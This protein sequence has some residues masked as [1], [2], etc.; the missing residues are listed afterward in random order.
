M[1]KKPAEFHVFRIGRV[2]WR[3]IKFIMG[4]LMWFAVFCC[5]L[6][7]AV[8]IYDATRTLIDTGENYFQYPYAAEGIYVDPHGYAILLRKNKRY[9]MC[10]VKDC[11]EGDWYDMLGPRP[12]LEWV[13]RRTPKRMVTLE[14]IYTTALGQRFYRNVRMRHDKDWHLPWYQPQPLVPA[15]P[16]LVGQIENCRWLGDMPCFAYGHA[17]DSFRKSASFADPGK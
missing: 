13:L 1:D 8:L 6:M 9:R 16:H 7:G 12:A 17:G 5:T 2:I 3:S 11:I 10:D 15:S 14:N 4:R